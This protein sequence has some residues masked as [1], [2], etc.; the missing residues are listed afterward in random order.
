ML[1]YAIHFKQE[2][3]KHICMDKSPILMVFRFHHGS[4]YEQLEQLPETC[5]CRRCAPSPPTPLD[6]LRT[7]PLPEPPSLA[8]TSPSST[9][10]ASTGADSCTN[11]SKYS[12]SNARAPL[13]PYQGA[14]REDLPTGVL[15]IL[16]IST[17]Y[18]LIRHSSTPLSDLTNDLTDR[19]RTVRHI[20]RCHVSISGVIGLSKYWG[21]YPIRAFY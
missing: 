14:M 4:D 21:I 6:L 15:L 12:S 8:V 9:L 17:T 13:C 11:W 10:Y 18:I 19:V 20:A 2:P 16:A 1:A 7:S 3:G 5:R